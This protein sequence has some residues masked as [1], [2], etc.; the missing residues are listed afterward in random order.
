MINLIPPEGQKVVAREYILRVG[1]TMCILFGFVTLILVVAHVP[2]YVLIGAQVESL[3][4][5]VEQE[6][7][8]VDE[9]GVIEKEMQETE[10]ILAQLKKSETTILKSDVIAEIKKRAPNAVTLNAFTVTL[11]GQKSDVIQVQGVANTR[12]ALADFTNQLE[13]SSMFASANVP[14]SD[15]VRDTD[16]PFTVT[17]TLETP[18]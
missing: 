11:T 3:K 12:E 1:S 17:L 10:A 13:A 4:A 15:L 2:T 9:I 6:S 18:K 16:L 8:K 14:I 7:S 5:T